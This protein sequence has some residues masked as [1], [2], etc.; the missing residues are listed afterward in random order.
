V[1]VFCIAFYFAMGSMAQ[2]PDLDVAPK[3]K[4]KTRFYSAYPALKVQPAPVYSL[5]TK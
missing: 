3:A 2:L 1:A 5:R 4:P